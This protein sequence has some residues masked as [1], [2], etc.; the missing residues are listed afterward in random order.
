LKTESSGISRNKTVCKSLMSTR[1]LAQ[2]VAAFLKKGDIVLFYGDLGAGKTFFIK[3]L[4][5]FFGVPKDLVVSPSFNIVRTYR[6][7]EKNIV[8]HHFDL[9]RIRN[10]EE[11][12]FFEFEDYLEENSILFIE[13]ADRL[14]KIT[15]PGRAISVAITITGERQ[16]EFTIAPWISSQ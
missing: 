8:L 10:E 6:A 7:G 4:A 13:W 2:E 15:F 9:Y 3:E 12:A 1:R 5:G 14:G 11:V 16:R